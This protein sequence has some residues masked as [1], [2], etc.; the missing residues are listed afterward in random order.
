[1]MEALYDLVEWEKSLRIAG[2]VEY[3]EMTFDV[4]L[5]KD[6]PRPNGAMTNAEHEAVRK[7]LRLLIEASDATPTMTSEE[8][9]VTTGWPQRIKPVAEQA[10]KLMLQRN[11]FSEDKEEAEPSAGP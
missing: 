7:V 1:M 11:R 5:W 10:H 3:F 6:A 2:F 4:F 8:Q 9:F